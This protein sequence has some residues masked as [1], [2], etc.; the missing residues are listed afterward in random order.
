[1]N[2]SSDSGVC[3]TTTNCHTNNKGATILVL[4]GRETTIMFIVLFVA[5]CYSMHNY[6]DDIDLKN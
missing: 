4:F 1:M 2:I 6:T 3:E 5:N